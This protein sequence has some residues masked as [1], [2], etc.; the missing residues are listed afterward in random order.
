EK[1]VM[2]ILGIVTSLFGGGL[3]G[4]IG[5]GTEKIFAYKAK[6]LAIEENREKYA[7]EVNMKRADAEIMAQE[8]AART[9]VADIEAVAKVDVA[10]AKAFSASFN[11]PV[12]YSQ[13]DL[14]KK[15]NWLMVVL[16]TIRGLVRPGLTLYLCAITTVLYLRAR[17][18]VP[19]EVSVD[20]ALGMV[21]SITNTILYLTTTCV[22]WWFGTRNKKPQK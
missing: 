9:K 20:Q 19:S 21:D 1:P 16:D 8:W 18:L 11:E 7:H 10:D 5:G 4:L 15:Q 14:T 13:G 3:T 22:L 2:D 12:R 6:K 17:S